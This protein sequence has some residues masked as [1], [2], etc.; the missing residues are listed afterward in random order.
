[1]QLVLVEDV[2]HLGRQ[3]DVV[4]VKHGYGRNYLLPYGLAV[5][6]DAHNLKRLDA[7]KITV[8]KAQEARIADLKV[9]AEQLARMPAFTMEANATEDGHLYGSIG[10]VEIS[11]LLKSKNLNVEPAMVLMEHA[12]KE[13][14]IL[15][16]S[17][18]R[19]R[20][21][22]RLEDPGAGRRRHRAGRRN[23]DAKIIQDRGTENTE[24]SQ[25]KAKHKMI[26]C[27]ALLCDSSVFSVPLWLSSFWIDCYE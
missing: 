9:L 14:N 24:E 21:R 26:T 25:R 17:A 11:K 20:P 22:H 7:Y 19:P 5:V 15:S 3:G 12:I 27:L 13:A 16:R 6:P 1:M 2:T 18:A 4:E 10:P 23:K 8:K